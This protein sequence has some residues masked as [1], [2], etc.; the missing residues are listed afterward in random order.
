MR[1]K[2]FRMDG[3]ATGLNA[4][5]YNGQ[6][7][8]HAPAFAVP[9]GLRPVKG[10]EEATDGVFGYAGTLVGYRQKDFVSFPAD[11]D[12]NGSHLACISDGVSQDI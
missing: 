12:L 5:L 9:Y 4:G 10:L 8:A 6:P 7:K 11:C 1:S 2:V 3:S